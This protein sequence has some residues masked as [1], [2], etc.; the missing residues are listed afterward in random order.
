MVGWTWFYYTSTNIYLLDIC[1]VEES[2][3]WKSILICTT[4]LVGRGSTTLALTSTSSTY[5]LLKNQIKTIKVNFRV[6][7]IRIISNQQHCANKDF[8]MTLQRRYLH[9]LF[10]LARQPRQFTFTMKE[11][12][13]MKVC[14]HFK[15]VVIITEMLSL[16]PRIRQGYLCD[17]KNTRF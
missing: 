2:K 15:H 9:S 10:T 7:E 1:V 11:Y 3:Q 14:C 6:L 16:V 13:L 8:I 17:K 4:W 5:V 12:M